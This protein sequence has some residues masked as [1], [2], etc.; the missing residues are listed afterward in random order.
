MG[1]NVA[2]CKYKYQ[3]KEKFN[4]KPYCTCLNKLCEDIAFVCD[5]NCQIYEDYKQ[6]QAKETELIMAKAD[7]CRGCKYS[8][9]YKKLKQVFNEI[10]STA[11]HLYYQSITDPVKREKAIYSIIDLINS[12]EDINVPRKERKLM[13]KDILL[14]CFW[15]IFTAVF[16]YC[17]ES[18]PTYKFFMALVS[19][20]V[21]LNLERA[22]NERKDK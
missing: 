11:G 3:S 7:L 4:G 6:L 1:I 19:V 10:K 8:D 9:G 5:E 21:L 14:M 16:I 2:R 15:A 17:I 12:V 20:L 13:I 18:L 22:C